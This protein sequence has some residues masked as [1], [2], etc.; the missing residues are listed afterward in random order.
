[1]KNRN[2]HSRKSGPGRRHKQGYKQKSKK[3]RSGI[4][5]LTLHLS[6]R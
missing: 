5:P 4:N 6:A 1:M 2:P 3:L